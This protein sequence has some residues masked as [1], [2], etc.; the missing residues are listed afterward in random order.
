MELNP[1][2]RIAHDPH[3]G[4]KGAQI[5]AAAITARLQQYASSADG[6]VLRWRAAMD[7]SRELKATL[8]V[9]PGGVIWK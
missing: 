3:P 5:I 9:S 4:V 6:P 1:A 7:L 2:W 8:A